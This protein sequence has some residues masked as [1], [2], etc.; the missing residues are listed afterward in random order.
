MASGAYDYGVMGEEIQS[1]FPGCIGVNGTANTSILTQ[2]SSS[3]AKTTLTTSSGSATSLTA[4]TTVSGIVS[5]TDTSSQ[6]ADGAH[7]AGAGTASVTGAST[8]ASNIHSGATR[9]VFVG[10]GLV[11]T[12]VLGAIAFVAL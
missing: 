9:E 10:F 11:G 5:G 2:S 12:V 6:G 7:G 3:L 8:T 4:A 1:T